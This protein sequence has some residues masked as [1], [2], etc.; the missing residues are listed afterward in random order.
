[1]QFYLESK[2][3]HRKMTRHGSNWL[4]GGKRLRTS[5]FLASVLKKSLGFRLHHT[6]HS[7]HRLQMPQTSGIGET[8]SDPSSADSL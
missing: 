7:S 3:M 4:L 8:V 1:M 2:L 5:M 6:A